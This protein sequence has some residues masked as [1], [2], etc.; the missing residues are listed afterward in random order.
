MAKQTGQNT[1]ADEDGEFATTL[2]VIRPHDS[3]GSPGTGGTPPPRASTSGDH[4]VRSTPHAERNRT[5]VHQRR[6]HTHPVGTGMRTTVGYSIDALPRRWRVHW[7]PTCNTRKSG[8][9][10]RQLDGV[11]QRVKPQSLVRRSTA[12]RRRFELVS[13]SDQHGIR[14]FREFHYFHRQIYRGGW[15]RKRMAAH[16]AHDEFQSPLS[17]DLCQR[18]IPN[19]LRVGGHVGQNSYVES[20]GCRRRNDAGDDA[21]GPIIPTTRF[22]VNPGCNETVPSVLP[23]NGTIEPANSFLPVGLNQFK[24]T[25]AVWL[26][27]ATQG[28]NWDLF[29]VAP[30]SS[31]QKFLIG[32]WGHGCHSSRETTEYENANRTNS[33]AEVQH[34]LRVHDNV[35]GPFSTIIMPYQKG[36]TPTRTVTQQ[37]CGVQV[38]QGTETT[39]FNGSIATYA[40]RR[41]R[42]FTVYDTSTQSAYGFTA[43]G[44]PQEVVVRIRPGCVDNQRGRTESHQD[45]D[46]PGHV[47]PESGRGC[48]ALRQYFQL[49][50]H[51]RTA[52]G[53]CDDHFFAAPVTT[54]R[55]EQEHPRECGN[56]SE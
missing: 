17:S 7:N 27:H 14:L 3:G 46:A 10:S 24:F 47:V 40:G 8:A 56:P 43:S 52:G 29:M 6:V 45:F 34:I 16:G 35:G 55:T 42:M 33:F 5:V 51:R 1:T 36:N 13:N 4:R 18:H 38:L 22:N 12:P 53:P 25:G 15:K 23:S 28:I 39:C 11:R 49:H 20:D 37:A 41:S 50:F 32:N 26:Q 54:M 30:N 31:Q 48:H 2:A 44:G 19:F 9:G 21:Y